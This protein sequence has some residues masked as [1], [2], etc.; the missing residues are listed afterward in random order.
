MVEYFLVGGRM[1][2]AR[3]ENWGER[4]ELV[5]QNIKKERRESR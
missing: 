5:L 3:R 2:G 1:K 4:R